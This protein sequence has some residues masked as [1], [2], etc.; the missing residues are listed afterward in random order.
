M[1]PLLKCSYAPVPNVGAIVVVAEENRTAY[2][3]L[4]TDC[5]IVRPE[6]F[7]SVCVAFR[8]VLCAG[9]VTVLRHHDRLARESSVESVEMPGGVL[10]RAGR[11]SSEILI[12][13]D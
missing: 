5:R 6:D 8:P 12:G 10:R 11:P 9:A 7:D 2:E 1:H 13:L 4:G 3:V